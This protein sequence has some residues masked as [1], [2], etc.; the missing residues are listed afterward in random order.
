MLPPGLQSSYKTYKEDT[1]AIATWLAISAKQCGYSADLLD[2][3]GVDSTKAVQASKRLKGK[4]RKNAQK[5]ST[6]NANSSGN[7]PR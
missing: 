2:R 3:E 4:A 7:A 6:G 5:A 1:K